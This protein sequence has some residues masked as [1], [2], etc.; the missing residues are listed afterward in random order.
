MVGVHA[1]LVVGTGADDDE[2]V[3][4]P[5]KFIGAEAEGVE[6]AGT[7]EVDV[8]SSSPQPSS[9]AGVDVGADAEE[10]DVGSSSPQSS[11]STG[12]DVGTGAEEELEELGLPSSQVTL[13]G[14]WH[15]AGRELMSWVAK[16][17]WQQSVKN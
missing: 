2:T 4:S 13:A 14:I 15:C 9:S 3:G 6:E 5:P 8:G 10:V 7:E 17:G 12:V 1:E 16:R 11:S